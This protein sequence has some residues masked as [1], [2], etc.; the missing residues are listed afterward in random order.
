MTKTYKTAKGKEVDIEAL[1]IMNENN[2]AVG[3]M[4]VNARGDEL[5]PGGVV[6]KTAQERALEHASQTQKVV[7]RNISVKPNVDEEVETPVKAEKQERK[8]K[9]KVTEVIDEDGNIDIIDES[10]I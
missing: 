6:V 1:R 2:V 7:K 10:G 5:G 4:G 8:A 3:N 9:P